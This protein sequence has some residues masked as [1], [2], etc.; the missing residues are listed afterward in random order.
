MANTKNT[1]FQSVALFHQNS[2]NIHS[3]G[4][5]IMHINAQSCANLSTFDEITH[6]IELCKFKIHV[7]IIGETW[8]QQTDCNLYEIAGYRSLHSCRQHRRG[9]GL[10]VYVRNELNIS[11]HTINSTQFNYIQ[12]TIDITHSKPLN[13]IGFYRPPH[14]SNLRDFLD[15]C[16]NILSNTSNSQSLF[17]GDTNINVKEEYRSSCKDQYTDLLSAHGFRLCNSAITRAA[18]NTVIDHVFSN[19]THKHT[20]HTS[21][22]ECDFSD[23]N[24]LVT[25][26]AIGVYEANIN[27]MYKR[28]DYTTMRE[29]LLQRTQALPHTDD[30]NLA[31]DAFLSVFTECADLSTQ[32]RSNKIKQTKRCFWLS[33]YPNMAKLL[34]RK[35]YLLRKRKKLR[36]KRKSTE[37]IDQKIN[38]LSKNISKWKGVAKNAYYERIFDQ[39]ITSRDKWKQLNILL[40]GGRKPPPDI[41]IR[42]NGAVTS[43]ETT[44]DHFAEYFARIG[45]EFSDKIPV[46][47]DDHPNSLNT[48][49]RHTKNI[50]LHPTDPA[51]INAVISGLNANKASGI[52]HISAKVVKECSPII[53]PII[54]E[55]INMAYLTGTYP[56]ALKHAKVIPIHK[57]GEMESIENY[58]PISILPA[59]NLIFE[60]TIHCRMYG[61]LSRNN[62]FLDTQYGFRPNSSTKVAITDTLDLIERIMERGLLTTGV[63]MDMSKAF[64]CV[65]HTILLYKLESAGIRGTPLRLLQSYLTDRRITVCVNGHSSNSIPIN[66]G[67]PQ[68]SCLGPLLYLTYIN[69]LG[70]LPLEGKITLFADDTTILYAANTRSECT[71]AATRDLQI[72]SEYFRINKLTLN[73]TKTKAINFGHDKEDG[74]EHLT[75]THNDQPIQLTQEIKYLGVTL[76]HK[77]RWHAHINSI[78][79]K[80]ASAVGVISKL[81]AFLPSR[82]LKDLY[83]AL[84]HS[85][86][87]YAAIGWGSANATH[88]KRIQTL[89]NRALKRCFR[90]KTR[91]NTINLFRQ[92]AKNV[93]PV[94][95]LRYYQA[96]LF[97]H[98]TIHKRIHTN[99]DM[100]IWENR[101]NL[102]RNGLLVSVPTFTSTHGQ[103][104]ISYYGPVNFNN[105]SQELRDINSGFQFKK[106]L[107]CDI[108]KNLNKYF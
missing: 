57:G 15:V 55:I 18:A 34:K 47:N 90:L 96:T 35:A 41:Q 81:S 62:F 7:I 85:R 65:N 3:K 83:F 71:N 11:S 46:K 76:D 104:A 94:V 61:F 82:V 101:R 99:T 66:I 93:I 50:F 49:R 87:E 53:S 59:F 32:L 108:L 77:L 63:F 69:D 38:E 37:C 68:G 33:N 95:A 25:N 64:D 91:H 105:L 12:T 86:I 27:P 97:T 58:R 88:L 74:S 31:Y 8:F 17:V 19:L 20:H 44:P 39:A 48:I 107:K 67:V 73:L 40:S 78:A 2:T 98:Q 79:K 43:K 60:K 4:L 5:N 102:R 1:T 106:A 51:E 52:D 23:H 54:S 92:K 45:H 10:S 14:S 24:I 80:I 72:V 75:I 6:F 42:A 16:D 84:V 89:Q 56:N 36:E 100:K 28:I 70:D 26:V 29:L 30:T 13:I 9:A 103:N 21:T 22:I